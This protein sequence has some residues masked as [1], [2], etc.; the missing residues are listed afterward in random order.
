MQDLKQLYLDTTDKK[1]NISQKK[2]RKNMQDLNVPPPDL[3]LLLL[4]VL[5]VAVV[6]VALLVAGC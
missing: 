5:L 2:I 4:V 6:L 3:L 1:S